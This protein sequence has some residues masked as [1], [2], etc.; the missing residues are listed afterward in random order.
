MTIRTISLRTKLIASFLAVIVLGGVLTLS[1]G[2]KLVEDII[3]SQAQDKVNFDLETARILY[4]HKLYELKQTLVLTARREG[5]RAAEKGKDYAVLKKNLGRIKEDNGLDILEMIGPEGRVELC[6][7]R[8]VEAHAERSGRPLVKRALGGQAAEG[9]T[10]F[11]R[12]ELLQED[13]RLAKQALIGRDD[14]LKSSHRAEKEE[15]AGMMLMAAAPVVDEDDRVLGVLFGGILL[16]RNFE[17]VDSVKEAVY[18]DRT[19]KGVDMGTAT[20]FLANLR[21][22]TNAL[23]G[24]GARAVG[25]LASEEVE[26][27]VLVEGRTWTRR[28]FV[29]NDWYL[30]SYA[31]IR[32]IENNI[33]GMLSVALLEKPYIDAKNRVMLIFAGIAC[34]CVVLLLVI[35]YF[36]T[37]SIIRPLRTMVD[38][39]EKISRGDLSHKIDVKSGDEIGHLASSFNR[40]TDDLKDANEQLVDWGRTLERKVDERTRELREMHRGM[41]QSE[42]LASLGKL[43]AGIAHEINNPLGGV[44]IYAHL[45]LEDMKEDDPDRENVEKIIKETTRCKNIVKDLLDF[46]RPKE[47]SK[48]E[49]DING[50][51][52]KSLSMIERQAQFRN[53]TIVKSLAGDMPRI[54]ADADQLQQV[55]MNI[56]INSAESMDTKGDLTLKTYHDSMKGRVVIECSDTGCGIPDEHLDRIFEPFFTTKEVGKGTGLGLA[57]SYGIVTRHGGSITVESKAGKGTTFTVRLPSGGDRK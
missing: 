11:S 20:I 29:V 33:I 9:T 19:Y 31:P 50:L 54:T 10:M 26:R 30:A 42:K 25:T 57:V 27:A 49:V 14:A 6:F 21:I 17:I 45:V 28:A 38:A 8:A 44:L 48:D 4:N 56:V 1:L 53:I 36:S 15:G 32:D 51:L 23:A 16:N 55:F 41:V 46:A 35:L 22:S 18:K 7:S 5:I 12:D 39:T 37:T 2:N 47:P 40:M 24:D 13:P 3:I 34:V 43:S 52:E